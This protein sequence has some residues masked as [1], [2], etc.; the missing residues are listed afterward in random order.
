MLDETLQLALDASV[1]INFLGSGIPDLLMQAY[2]GRTLVAEQVYR[3]VYSDPGKRVQPR[4]WLESLQARGLIEIV[5][6]S[7]TALPYYLDFGAVGLDDGEAATL[8]LALDRN[9]IPVIDEKRARRIYTSNYP[10]AKMLSTADLFYELSQRGALQEEVLRTAL[11]HAIRVARMNIPPET[12]DW[13]IA[14]IG[15][16]NAELCSSIPKFLRKNLHD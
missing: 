3:E 16:E 10:G 11:F 13:A 8:A 1:L 2:A 15:P 4:E 7:G 9:A 6:L 14:T 5:R 12:V